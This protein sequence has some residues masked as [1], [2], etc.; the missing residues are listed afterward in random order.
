MREYG[1]PIISYSLDMTEA[2]NFIEKEFAAGKVIHANEVALRFNLDV[3]I[4]S[5]IVRDIV[6]QE[7][8]PLTT[9]NSSTSANSSNELKRT[10]IRHLIDLLYKELTERLIELR[11]KNSLKRVDLEAI[12]IILSITSENEFEDKKNLLLGELVIS[13]RKKAILEKIRIEIDKRSLGLIYLLEEQDEVNQAINRL[14]MLQ[15]KEYQ[16]QFENEIRA[17]LAGS[18]NQNPKYHYRYY[19]DN[20]TGV[21]TPL[22]SDEDIGNL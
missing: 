9:P 4:I 5:R 14:V 18:A 16:N 8:S 19:V 10:R 1:M 21:V 2:R 22:S 7:E 13:V 15:G 6:Q 20:E 17:L 3:K 12:A 11:L